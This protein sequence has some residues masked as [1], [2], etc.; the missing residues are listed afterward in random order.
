MSG[1]LPSPRAFL[2]SLL[3]ELS[4]QQPASNGSAIAAT[5]PLTSASPAIK[6]LFLTL[7]C[8]FPTEFLPALDLLDRG[9]VSQ[10]SVISESHADRGDTGRPL[11]GGL[12]LDGEGGGK[13]E[14]YYVGSSHAS[15]RSGGSSSSGPFAS[16]SRNPPPQASST[17]TSNTYEVRLASWNCSCPAFAFAAFP[18]SPPA[19]SRTHSPPAPFFGGHLLDRDTTPP[20]CKHLLACVIA[21]HCPALFRGYIVEELVELE[22]IAGRGAGW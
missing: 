12:S 18:T 20:I 16:K 8:I 10:F 14:V 15:L 6:A 2:T 7:H 17:S 9:L 13:C 5:N 22:E 1:D 21:E 3:S 19:V 4:T 11:E